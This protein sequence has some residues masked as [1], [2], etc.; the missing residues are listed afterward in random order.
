M[1]MDDIR[2]E[3]GMKLS[4][5]FVCIGISWAAVWFGGHFLL[6]L[7]VYLWFSAIV[8]AQFFPNL[9]D[10]EITEIRR[11]QWMERQAKEDDST[12]SDLR[13]RPPKDSTDN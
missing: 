8:V 7:A 5:L 3:P 4:H 10:E 11:Q 9:T 13:E 2:T 12:D 6:F 1:T